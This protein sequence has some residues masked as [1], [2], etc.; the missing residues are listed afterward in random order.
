MPNVDNVDLQGVLRNM[1]AVARND[2]DVVHQNVAYGHLGWCLYLTLGGLVLR[3]VATDLQLLEARG[4]LLN[5]HSASWSKNSGSSCSKWA[6][7]TC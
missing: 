5:I 2:G 6:R 3:D 4:Q 7:S 1:A